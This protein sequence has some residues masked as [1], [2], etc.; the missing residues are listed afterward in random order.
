MHKQIPA[1]NH[2][3]F[4]PQKQEWAHTP[5]KVRKN[6]NSRVDKRVWVC[7]KQIKTLTGDLGNISESS[8]LYR[9]TGC[10]DLDLSAGQ[11]THIFPHAGNNF[12]EINPISL[13]SSVWEERTMR[14]QVYNENCEAHYWRLKGKWSIKQQKTIIYNQTMNFTT[15]TEIIMSQN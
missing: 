15:T 1:V 10:R 3:F 6:L 5:T 7:L 14:S 4:E 11:H 12:R 9:L 2:C 13:N 8:F